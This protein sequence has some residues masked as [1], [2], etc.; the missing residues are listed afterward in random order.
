MYY[1]LKTT[2]EQPSIVL[3]HSLAQQKKKLLM[4]SPTEGQAS[5][6]SATLL[7]EGFQLEISDALDNCEKTIEHHSPDLIL[8][9][10]VAPSMELI[11][12]CH[13]LRAQYPG[14]I[15]ILS[16]THNEML[17]VLSLE[18][19]VDDFLTKPLS[20][21]FI[22]AKIRA[23]LRRCQELRNHNHKKVHLGELT[24][25]SER[26]E[27]MSK[28]EVVDLTTREF[29]VLWCL[30]QNNR[31]VLSRDDIHRQLYNSEYNGFDRSIDIYISRIRQKIGDDPSHPRYLKTV[32]GSGYLLADERPT[33]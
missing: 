8:F 26:R 11:S 4:F 29:D 10:T 32:R 16:E 19:G 33:Q 31:K 30:A 18:M 5:K 17:Q 12:L 6:L 13:S 7:L 21:A 24:I 14:P 25:D 20:D 2:S 1:N 28:N 27:V 9:N 3:S 22:L 15:I 23:L